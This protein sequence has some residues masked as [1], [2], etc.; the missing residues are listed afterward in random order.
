MNSAW[1]CLLFSNKISEVHHH[2]FMLQQ[3]QWHMMHTVKYKQ[4]WLIQFVVFSK[5]QTSGKYK[6]NNTVY[7]IFNYMEFS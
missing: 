5:K 1:N 2:V 7:L 3:I 6:Y 4:C